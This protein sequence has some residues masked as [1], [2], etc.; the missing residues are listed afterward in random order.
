MK[1]QK[2]IS[3][4]VAAAEAEVV[5][6]TLRKSDH[7]RR[8]FV[9]VNEDATVHHSAAQCRAEWR[10]LLPTKITT[11]TPKCIIMLISMLAAQ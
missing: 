6:P 4:S 10:H 5:V 9:V 8:I 2:E 1:L 11:E 7:T 3:C